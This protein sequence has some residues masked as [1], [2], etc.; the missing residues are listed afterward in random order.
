MWKLKAA[1][2]G[3]LIVA[4]A[5]SGVVLAQ[6]VKQVKDLCIVAFVDRLARDREVVSARQ[7]QA[8]CACYANRN[9]QGLNNDDCP[10]YSAVTAQQMREKFYGDW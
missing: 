5:N 2:T 10:S 4:T 9:A 3:L 8:T 1:I 6:S 7:I